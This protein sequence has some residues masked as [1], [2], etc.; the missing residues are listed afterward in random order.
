MKSKKNT[1]VCHCRRA[2]YFSTFRQIEV[3]KNKVKSGGRNIFMAFEFVLY[4]TERGDH[5]KNSAKGNPVV[6]PG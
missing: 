6:T 2:S 5:Y 1:G 3:V 4:V